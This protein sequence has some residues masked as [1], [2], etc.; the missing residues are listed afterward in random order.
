MIINLKEAFPLLDPEV[1]P[2]ASDIT[3]QIGG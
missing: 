1:F 2:Y 3:F